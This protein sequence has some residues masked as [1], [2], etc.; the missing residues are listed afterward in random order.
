MLYMTDRSVMKKIVCNTNNSLSTFHSLKL[1]FHRI[2]QESAE[3]LYIIFYRALWMEK[4][5]TSKDHCDDSL[6]HH[7]TDFSNVANS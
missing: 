3:F 4:I 2:S 5:E 6:Y 7:T 1:P